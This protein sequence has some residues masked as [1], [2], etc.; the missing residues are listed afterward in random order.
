MDRFS[1]SATIVQLNR[2]AGDHAVTVDP[3]E[4]EAV[5]RAADRSWQEFPYYEMRY[6]ERGQR[7]GLS[8]GAWLV[9]LCEARPSVA[10]EQIRWLGFT[11][12]SRGMPQL[13]LES[14]LEFLRVELTQSVPE[15]QARYQRLGHYAEALREQRQSQIPEQELRS[16]AAAFAARA[17][18]SFDL[19]RMGEI[20]VSAVADEAAGVERAVASLETWACDPDRFPTAW[21]EA[22]RSTIAE[23]RARAGRTRN[24]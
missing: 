8:D 1:H 7:F 19:P 18:Q 22:V 23:A 13:L 15:R 10:L 20:L 17:G 5:K 2:E 9:T 24:R 14:H 21:I 3:R 6:G 11:L 12:S 16:L 4:L